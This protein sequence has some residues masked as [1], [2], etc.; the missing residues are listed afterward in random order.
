MPST[1]SPN[2]S[3]ILP[4]VGSQPSPTWAQDLNASLSIVDQHDHSSGNGVPITPAGLNISSDLSFQENNAV[5]VRS[6]R[7]TAQGSP[8][9]LPTDLNCAY[10]SGVD[11]YYNDGNG[12]QIQ[13]TAS[14][15]VAGSPGSIGSLVSPASCTYVSATPAFVFQS[16]ANTPAN[17]DGGSLVLRNIS[18]SSNGITINPPGALA[19]SY[20]VTF[21]AALPAGQRFATL[22][23]S[24]N[25]AATWNVDNSSLE[26]SSNV[27][28]VKALGITAAMLAADSVTTAKILNGNVTSAKLDTNIAVTGTLSSGGTLQQNAKNVLVSNTN[29]SSS[30][31]VVR[32]LVSAAGGVN[33]GEGWSCVRSGTGIYDI[34]FTTSFASD[35]VTTVSTTTEGLP[36]VL[37]TGTSSIQ[38]ETRNRTG[39]LVN[40]A[41]HFI[42]MGPRS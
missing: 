6:A 32:G 33:T 30:L 31:A 34:T 39:T 18:A 17:L 11:L 21:P 19:A 25:L 28:Q 12:N 29:A 37:A 5:A 36:S 9:A 20:S 26:I 7:F 14:G 35:P 10:V 38:I 24:G 42:S 13:I 2:M 23:A 16:A 27:L 15:G 3:L 40:Q 8:L 22:D 1:T 4:T 41:F